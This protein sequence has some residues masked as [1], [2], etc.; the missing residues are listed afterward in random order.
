MSA[1]EAA[2]I[3]DVVTV[4]SNLERYELPKPLLP[5]HNPC[6]YVCQS[7]R[8]SSSTNRVHHLH[9]RFLHHRLHHLHYRFVSLTFFT[10]GLFIIV[11]II[12]KPPTGF[13]KKVIAFG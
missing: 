13:F 12:F 5:R 10:P 6:G 8:V 11:F 4:G 2:E 9:Y 7:F 1:E 3:P